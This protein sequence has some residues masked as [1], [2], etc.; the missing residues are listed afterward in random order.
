[1]VSVTA[2]QR[3]SFPLLQ[4][5]WDALTFVHWRVAP[6]RVQALL[7]PGLEVD[8][9]DGS[10]WVGLT[11]FVMGNIRP[12][13]LGLPA[14]LRVPGPRRPHRVAD[15][16]STPETNLRTY[17]RGPDGRDGLWFL[18]IDAGSAA[19]AAVIRAS[20]GAPYHAARMSVEHD[21]RTVTYGSSRRR[22]HETYRLQV[23]PREP[24]VPSDLD[25]WVTSRWRAYTRHF[26]RLLATP[27][28]HEPWPLRR[29]TLQSLE[30]SLTD[31]VGLPGLTEPA[32]VHYSDGVH[33]VRL[34]RPAVVA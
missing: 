2:E 27:V 1:M 6:T 25:I 23:E 9:H 20:V 10:A 19:L 3:V 4:A 16:T 18:T 28:E 14:G 24:I 8:V 26:G 5:S 34:G 11:P 29:A 32:L 13:G 31:S 12:L 15:V 17:V 7:P 33:D 21:E 30:Q 22:S